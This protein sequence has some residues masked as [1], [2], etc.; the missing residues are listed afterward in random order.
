MSHITGRSGFVMRTGGAVL[1]LV[2]LLCVPR[3]GAATE[4]G[5]VHASVRTLGL[6]T[7]VIRP[8]ST[9]ATQVHAPTL[10]LLS[11]DARNIQGSGL[12]GAMYGFLAQQ[13]GSAWT[14]RSADVMTG[15]V[16]WEG[17]DNR[18][19]VQAG[20]LAVF[21]G[22]PR[23]VFLDGAATTVRLPG[24]LRVDGYAG[25]GLYETFEKAFS[26]P[27]YGG[28][29]AWMPW[30]I[31]HIGIA[32]Q[33]VDEARATGSGTEAARRTVGVDASLRA[34]KPLLLTG[35]YAHDLIGGGLQEARLDA[36]YRLSPHLAVHA[37]GEVRDPLAWLPKTSIFNAFVA[38]TD[39]LVGGGF[40]LDT[41][42]A[43]AVSGGYDR[44]LTGA[45]G[46]DGY[47]A[48]AET[49]LRID[50]A[51]RYRAGLQ[52]GR[53]FN[54]ENGY[55][56]VRL[57]VTAKA[58]MRWT[59]T[60]DLDGYQF[61]HAIHDETMSTRALVGV[62]C[63]V[64]SGVV[65]GLDGQLWRN[66]YFEAQAM[67]LLTLAVNEQTVLRPPPPIQPPP[68]TT[69]EPTADEDEED[70]EDKDDDDKPAAPKAEPGAAPAP[71]AS[72]AADEDDD[73]DEKPAPQAPPA[74]GGQP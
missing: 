51:G 21:A 9:V 41:P 58:G 17:M 69:S 12:F 68:R 20:R 30:E 50:P 6:A 15:Y 25:S 61:F 38:R 10:E 60:G 5:D 19:R 22:A 46:L 2:A 39:G 47:R 23:Y 57:Y 36:A 34:W 45:G 52:F 26:A 33:G 63:A 74:A 43:L 71:G 14:G 73:E 59:L 40:D 31:G 53:L 72:K 55:N 29:I 62:R 24:N 56:Q 64:T 54:G 8:G 32:A 1:A 3:L 7:G 18:V 27:V 11:I 44:F 42:G 35:T 67:G 70:K 28:R 13:W 4:L 16:G 49:R 37:R 65:V 66:P 48:F